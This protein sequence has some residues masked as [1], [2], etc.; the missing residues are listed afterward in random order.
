MFL[1]LEGGDILQVVVCPCRWVYKGKVLSWDAGCVL[2]LGSSEGQNAFAKC[3]ARR[4]RVVGNPKR[5]DG[6]LEGVAKTFDVGVAVLG[7]DS[8]DALWLRESEAESDWGA[9]VEYVDGV[10]G[11]V[12]A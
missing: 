9:I 7:N 3:L 5:F 6:I 11:D 1:L 4:S 12:K 8:F 10:G 2:V